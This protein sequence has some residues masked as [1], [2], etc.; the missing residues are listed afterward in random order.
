MSTLSEIQDAV[1]R[2]PLGQADQGWPGVG[3]W[4]RPPARP[5]HAPTRA[6]VL[7]DLDVLQERPAENRVVVDALDVRLDDEDPVEVEDRDHRRILHEQLLG[8]LVLP[9]ALVLV[10][11]PARVVDQLVEIRVL[12]VRV[13]EVRRRFEELVVPVGRVAPVRAP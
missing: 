1:A 10:G 7:L 8:L 13:V 4:P 11:H 5:R 9:D 3:G 6:L 12:P 2:L